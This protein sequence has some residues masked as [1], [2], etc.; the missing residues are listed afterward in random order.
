MTNNNQIPAPTNNGKTVAI[1]SYITWIGWI[2]AFVM[3]NSNKTS[4]GVFHLRQSGFL[5]LISIALPIIRSIF[6][7]IS[8]LS[9]IIN[10]AVGIA[11]IALFVFWIIGLLA[12][13]NGEEKRVPFVGNMAQDLLSGLK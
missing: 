4:F 6:S 2:I 12:A 9:W 13:I 1:I 3:H 8:G 10:L 7:G 5:Y 11:G